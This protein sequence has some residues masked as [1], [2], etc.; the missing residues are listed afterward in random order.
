MAK[1]DSSQPLKDKTFNEKVFEDHNSIWND[2]NPTQLV[3]TI[4]EKHLRLEIKQI[5]NITLK[6]GG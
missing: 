3:H 4:S 1:F 5:I 6:V 2:T